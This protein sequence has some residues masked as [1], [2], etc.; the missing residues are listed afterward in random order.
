MKVEGSNITINDSVYNKMSIIPKGACEQDSL[1]SEY[2]AVEYIESSGT[3]YIDTNYVPNQNTKV[4]VDFQNVVSNENFTIL[5]ARNTPN[6]PRKGIMVGVGVSYTKFVSM[7]GD[8]SENIQLSDNNLNKNNVEVSKNGYYFNGNLITTPSQDNWTINQ[9]IYLFAMHQGD[10]TSITLFAKTK[11]YA[12]KIWE[13]NVLV[14]N[15]IPCYRK[16]DNVIGLY[17]LVNN[18]FYTNAGTGTFNKGNDVSIPNPD[19]PQD[20][21]VV[22]GDNSVVVQNKNLVDDIIVFKGYSIGGNGGL[23]V[24]SNF[25]TYIAP[26]IQ[27]QSYYVT[28]DDGNLVL[29]Y[30]TSKPTLESVTYDNT[31]HVG[32]EKAFTAEIT[33]WI[34]FRTLADYATPQIEKGSAATSYVA[35]QIQSTTLHLGDIKL[36]GIG[37]YIDLP[38]KDGDTWKIRRNVGKVVLDGTQSLTLRNTSSNGTKTYALDNPFLYKLE[39]SDDGNILS[40]YYN[41]LHTVSGVISMYDPNDLLDVLGISLYYLE[42]STNRAVYINTKE[43][44]PIW[45]ETHNTEIYY[46]L[47]TPVEETI[48]DT[49]LINDLNALQELLSYD[50]TTNITVTSEDTNAQMEVEVTY[51]SESDMCEK[52]LFIF[53]KMKDKLYHIIRSL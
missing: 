26:V 23:S 51:T 45:F 17:D 33:G 6:A 8:V 16:S 44:L 2:Q 5:G 24:N 15:F 47:A 32:L 30:Y 3:Q 52:L 41:H 1:P 50:G 13:S 11:M 46:I 42:G 53:N 36:N 20:I 31:R 21:R 10:G 25:D 37:N 18:V 38:F 12:C 48:T 7:F 40:N 22:T 28:T 4:S 43:T 34:S 14:R 39:K 29:G 9:A 19:Y 27:G 49:T 35:P